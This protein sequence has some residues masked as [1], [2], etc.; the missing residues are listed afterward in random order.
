MYKKILVPID[1]SRTSELGLREAIRL[2][3][4]SR[5]TIRLVHVLEPAPALQGMEASF[6]DTL[7]NNMLQ[8]GDKILKK[9][10]AQ[11]ERNGIRA[12]TVFHRKS[13]ERAADGIA[14]E[15][16]KW[17]ADVVVMGTHGRRGISRLMLGSNAEATVHSSAVPVL[18]VRSPAK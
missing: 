9:A 6:T 3:A 8:F 13:Q 7:L 16:R 1:G 2:A 10:Q 12:E 15:A 18:L 4:G 14:A 11:I 5:A 17:K